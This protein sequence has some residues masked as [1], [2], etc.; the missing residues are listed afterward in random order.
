MDVGGYSGTSVQLLATTGTLQTKQRG[1][2]RGYF[3]TR[4]LA[5]HCVFARPRIMNGTWSSCMPCCGSPFVSTDS[6]S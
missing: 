1:F 4:R 2:N 3:L 5:V 6:A